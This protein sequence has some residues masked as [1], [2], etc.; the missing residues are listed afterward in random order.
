MMN[1]TEK[2]RGVVRG[3]IPAGLVTLVSLA[4][5]SLLIPPNMLPI[6]EPGARIAWA[7]PW[8]LLPVLTLMISIMR[9]ANH[10]FDTPE[11]IDGSGLTIGT[12]R[13]Q[14]L[15]A[16][17]QN[18]LEQTVMAGVLY[19]VWAAVMPHYWLRVIPMA[20]ILFATGR[21]LFTRGYARGAG[22][23]AMGFGLTMYPNAA[24]LATLVVVMALRLFSSV[25]SR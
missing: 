2:Q 8:L 25:P 10:R 21:L 15:R 16:V 11:D 18:T 14:I 1:L 19:L 22:G 20:A 23:R 24:M 17:L 3:V 6:D 9:V 12:P 5:I 7:A 13:I 4:G